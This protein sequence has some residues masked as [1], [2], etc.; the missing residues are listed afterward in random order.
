MNDHDQANSPTQGFDKLLLESAD[1]TLSV[2]EPKSTFYKLLDSKFAM[3]QSEIA[4]R[5]EEFNGILEDVS[6]GARRTSNCF[7][8]KRLQQKIVN[9]YFLTNVCG[10]KRL[11]RTRAD[12]IRA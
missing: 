12:H 10:R 8:A 6:A 9:S 7:F 2:L 3:K 5:V 1:E 11:F 4:F